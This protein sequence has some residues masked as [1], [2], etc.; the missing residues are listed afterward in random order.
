[1]LVGARVSLGILAAAI[2]VISL[3]TTRVATP[4]RDV[5]ADLSARRLV[6]LGDR[7]DN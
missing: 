6:T 4:P 1:M 7:Y 3:V 2:D 5:A